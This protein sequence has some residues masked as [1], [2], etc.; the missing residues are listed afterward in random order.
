MMT[1][2]LRKMVV[3]VPALTE[4]AIVPLRVSVCDV[5]SSLLLFSCKPCHSVF[6]QAS[7]AFISSSFQL[8]MVK[9]L[10]QVL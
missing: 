2:L 1:S 10:L 5:T 3:D 6:L 8:Q 7:L 4:N 9:M